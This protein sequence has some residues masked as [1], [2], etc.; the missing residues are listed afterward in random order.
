MRFEFW[1]RTKDGYSHPVYTLK[2]AR[3]LF[4]RLL[5]LRNGVSNLVTIYVKLR[6]GR[7]REQWEAIADVSKAIMKDCIRI[8]HEKLRDL[9]TLDEF[10]GAVFALARKVK[11]RDSLLRMVGKK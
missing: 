11:S 4:D 7:Q 9:D 10:A 8:D 5:R 6:S 1:S 3:E 2:N